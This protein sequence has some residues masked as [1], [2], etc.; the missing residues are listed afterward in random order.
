MATLGGV[1]AGSARAAPDIST[2]SPQ[3]D[4]DSSPSERHRTAPETTL[5]VS[6]DLFLTHTLTIS[7]VYVD[8]STQLRGAFGVHTFVS[9]PQCWHPIGN[10]AMLR[11][12]PTSSCEPARGPCGAEVD[13]EPKPCPDSAPKSASTATTSQRRRWPHGV[14]R[15]SYHHTEQA[16]ADLIGGTQQRRHNGRHH[17]QP[18]AG[19]VPDQ[20]T[21]TNDDV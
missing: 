18:T 4:T 11:P 13:A 17:A 2:R 1:S 6:R 19:G 5:R 9:E 12:D 3:P 7:G 8:R 10:G 15:V 20:R 16:R 21:T 14:P